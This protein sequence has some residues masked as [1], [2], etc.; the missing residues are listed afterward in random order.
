[1]LKS[2]KSDALN[3][4][5]YESREEMGR[6]AASDIAK[7]IR[8]LLSRQ[9]RAN[10]V[11]AA[12]PSQLDMLDALVQAPGIDWGK[13]NAFHMDEYIGLA[14][15]APQGFGNF[16]KRHLFSKL[17]F[18]SVCCIDS[19]AAAK[20]PD[21]ECQRYSRILGLN[22]ADIACMGIGENGHIAFND[23][24]AAFF[25]D[26]ET[27]KVVDLDDK[28]RM[29]QVNDGCFGS[30]AAVPRRA[31]TLTV[32]ALMAAKNIYCVVPGESKREA[33]LNAVRGGISTD[34]P[35]SILRAQPGATLY[36]D[37]ESGRDIL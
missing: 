6:C 23:P 3:V 8:G 15:D 14:S 26:P 22:P 32:S 37:M 30:L 35:A 27:V 10:V 31:I 13:V 18:G 2:F 36:A 12:A 9:G 5:I 17:P 20:D 28:C 24:H 1:M 25:D 16:L 11:F 29:Q 21:A 34:C 4:R 33:V 7:G 19:A